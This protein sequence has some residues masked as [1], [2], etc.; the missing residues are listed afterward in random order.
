MLVNQPYPSNTYNLVVQDL[1]RL[2][3]SNWE[4]LAYVEKLRVQEVC[5]YM[6]S[7]KEE[8]RTKS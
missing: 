1:E 5:V 4:G 8:I 3:F 7:V 2:E 6:G